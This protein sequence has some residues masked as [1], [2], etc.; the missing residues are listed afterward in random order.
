MN[1][2]PCAHCWIMNI[3][4]LDIMK[5]NIAEFEIVMETLN[6]SYISADLNDLIFLRAM[7]NTFC[8]RIVV[9]AESTDV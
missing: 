6:K 9:C 7:M 2:L 4:V 1:L 8:S 5:P 3:D